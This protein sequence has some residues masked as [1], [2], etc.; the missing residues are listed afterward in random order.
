MAHLRVRHVT[1]TQKRMV[2]GLA[3]KCVFVPI[4]KEIQTNLTE[5]LWELTERNQQK[6]AVNEQCQENENVKSSLKKD[7]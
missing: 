6:E 3:Q 2:N 4:S 7:V 1:S 5:N